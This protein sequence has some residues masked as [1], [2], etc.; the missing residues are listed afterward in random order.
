MFQQNYQ[1]KEGWSD[2]VD[3]IE[4]KRP[5]GVFKELNILLL[6]YYGRNIVCYLLLQFFVGTERCNIYKFN[7]A[8]FSPELTATCH[9]APITDV[10]FP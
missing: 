10:C 3:C 2:H 4:R 8:E 6:L 5:P 1:V 7:F 9:Y